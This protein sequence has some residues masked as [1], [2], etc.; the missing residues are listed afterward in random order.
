MP[1]QK[2]EAELTGQGLVPQREDFA[3]APKPT[4]TS[5]SSRSPGRAQL[6]KKGDTVQLTVSSGPSAEAGL[7]AHTSS[8][9]TLTQAEA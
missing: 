5:C 6:V 8:V 7:P 3:T 9:D 2:A 1:Y 4:R